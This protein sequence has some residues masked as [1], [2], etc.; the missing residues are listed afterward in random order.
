MQRSLSRIISYE[1]AAIV[2][3]HLEAMSQYVP[4]ACQ[5][6]DPPADILTCLERLLEIC[7]LP[8]TELCPDVL[9]EAYACQARV[10]D[11]LRLMNHQ[12][13]STFEQSEIGRILQRSRALCQ[14]TGGPSSDLSVA[15]VWDLLSP[16]K[17]DHLEVLGNG[18]YEA[19]WWNPIP[20]MDV[21]MLRRTQG[22]LIRDE[23]HNTKELPEGLC[24]QFSLLPSYTSDDEDS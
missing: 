10:G 7:Q 5:N 19:R 13:D 11:F 21:Y 4:I 1:L 14:S 3:R 15:Q 2:H 23:K 24:I 16:V 6:T 20:W 17:P 8:S 9:E 22:V 12:P 18:V